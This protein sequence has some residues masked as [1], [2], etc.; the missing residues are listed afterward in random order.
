M[1][2][3]SQP[4]GKFD[5]QIKKLVQD[6]QETLKTIKEVRGVGLS[7]VQIVVNKRLFA[8]ER[9]GQITFFI[10]PVIIRQSK[11]TLHQKLPVKGRFL[12]GCLS[13]PDV[14]GEVDRPYQIEAKWQDETGQEQ[15]AK[16]KGKEAAYWQHEYDHLEGVLFVD[17]VLAQKGKL[18]QT[19]KN[20]QGKEELT[21]VK[22]G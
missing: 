11:T 21:E 19:Q 17:R 16:F 10:N 22:L 5:Q 12:E 2:Q 9:S 1:R 4:V 18:Y 20:Q 7:A 15:Q 8:I 14:Y 13:I 6:V 3:R